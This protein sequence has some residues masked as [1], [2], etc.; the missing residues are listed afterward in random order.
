MR[1]PTAPWAA[2]FVALGACERPDPA[3]ADLE[4]L[5]RFAF[6]HY[7]PDGANDQ[8]LAD[9][10]TNLR[11]WLES[12]VGSAEEPWDAELQE[13]LSDIE[14]DTLDPAPEVREGSAALGVF[15]VQRTSCSLAEWEEIYLE[16]D[17]ASLFPGAYAS[18][19]RHDQ[20]DFDC[21]RD[22]RCGEATWHADIVKEQVI[23]GTITY[24]FEVRSGI[25]R[26][27]AVPP[28]GEDPVE[29]RLSRTWML[30]PAT[31]STPDLGDFRQNYQLEIL[32]PE[33]DG[34]LHFFALWTD[35][36]SETL[37]TESSV[38]VDGYV[39]GLHDT[40]ADLDVLCEGGTL[41]DEGCQHAGP[42]R[43]S[44]AILIPLILT[45]RGRG[46][47]QSS[48]ARSTEMTPLSFERS[49][50]I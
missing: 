2:L 15:S 12:E 37:N 23:L 29:A 39:D 33:G 10:A 18:Y 28:G 1:T 7:P 31:L 43:L 20:S 47:A 42:G 17:Q 22:G 5:V 35:L 14:L 13:R 36:Q 8:S 32:L 49:P 4:A 38:F 9:A 3:P 6:G 40:F 44:L 26:V 34:G 30:R 24:E 16:N 50:M 11:L 19:E 48:R 45:R 46:R 27:E 25:R 41:E 21:F